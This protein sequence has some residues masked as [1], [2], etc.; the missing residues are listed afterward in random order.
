VREGRETE[1]H[2]I[3]IHPRHLSWYER[4]VLRRQKNYNPE[5]DQ[6]D[7]LN[8]LRE[9]YEQIQHEKVSEDDQ[10]LDDKLSEKAR[11]YFEWESRSHSLPRT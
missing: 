8:E 7:K 10:A 3:A 2:G 9:L 4:I 11:S 1:Y 6:H 5:L